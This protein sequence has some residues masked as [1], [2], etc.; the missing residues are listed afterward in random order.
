MTGGRIIMELLSR[1]AGYA[2]GG[3]ASGAAGAAILKKV[4]LAGFSA[5]EGAKVGAAGNAVV[6]SALSIAALIIDHC[7]DC[8][9]KSD[10]K[11][12][13]NALAEV[14]ISVGTSTLG[15]ILGH[16]MLSH[17]A[18]MSLEQTA[19]ALAVGSSSIIG[20]ALAIAL[21]GGGC[22]IT[23]MGVTYCCD[24]GDNTPSTPSL[25]RVSSLFA[26]DNRNKGTDIE[27]PADAP[28]ENST[29]EPVIESTAPR[30]N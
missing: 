15:G 12:Q 9:D 19:A 30:P 6:G 4:G 10:K 8:K 14:I 1:S 23:G 17:I 28:S 5:L 26:Q 3:A 22:V 21:V 25:S 20:G 29:E 27:A 7:C 24:T 2:A 16:A 18:E 11:S 13:I